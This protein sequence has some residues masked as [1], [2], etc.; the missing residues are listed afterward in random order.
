MNI[1]KQQH[2]EVIFF[3]L[4]GVQVM[5]DYHLALIYGVQTRRINE[6]VKRNRKRFPDSFMFQQTQKEGNYLR[7]QIATTKRRIMPYDWFYGLDYAY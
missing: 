1:I 2:I 5:L 3:S 6:Q 7:S 4:R